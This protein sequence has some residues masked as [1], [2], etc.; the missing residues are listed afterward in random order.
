MI[1]EVIQEAI[2]IQMPGGLSDAILCR[3]DEN[4]RWPGV[5]HLS[6]VGGIRSAQI[7]MVRKLAA[8]GYAVLMPNLFYRTAR[9]PVLGPRPTLPPGASMEEIRKLGSSEA[10]TKRI[11]EVTSPL[12][13]EAIESDASSYV[14]FL[15]GLECVRHDHPLGVVGYC[16]SGAVAMRFAAARANRIAAC[17]SFHGGGLYLDSPASPHLL[18]PRIKAR[19]YF[20]HAVKDP[21]MSAEAIQK[22]DEALASWGGEYASEVYE[23]AYH[24][25]TA[26]DS[27]IYNPLQAERAFEK[28]T[29]LLAK[30]IQTV[31]IE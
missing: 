29:D 2:E 6:D 26:P 21:F 18:L 8:A 16:Y 23:G 4:Q 24:S 20:G 1:Q 10:M 15:L 19:L 17:A 27:P 25:W 3:P 31:K 22:L 12:T 13:P 30:T 14:D 9:P 5:I 7:E 11:A 28:L